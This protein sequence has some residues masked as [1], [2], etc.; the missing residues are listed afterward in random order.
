MLELAFYHHTLKATET[1][2]QQTSF[3]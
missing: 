1:Y 2:W 3:L